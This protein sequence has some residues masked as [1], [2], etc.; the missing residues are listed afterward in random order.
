M[1]VLHF[2][3]KRTGWAFF[4][5]LMILGWEKAEANNSTWKAMANGNWSDG[6]NWYSGSAPGS[7]SSTTNT[8]TAAFNAVYV[9]NN[10]AS[11]LTVSIDQTGQNISN[12]TFGSVGNFGPFTFTGN[13]LHLSSGGSIVS[14]AAQIFESFNNPLILEPASATSDGSYT[15]AATG[16]DLFNFHGPISGGTTTGA[17]TLN[18]GRVVSPFAST[19]SIVSGSIS[20]G[21]AA[22]GLSLK[23]SV[24]GTWLL[25]GS[26]TYTGSTIVGTGTGIKLSGYLNPVTK[27]VLDGSTFNYSPPS[28]IV[29]QTVNGLTITGYSVLRTDNT[30]GS[31]GLHVGSITRNPKAILDI[32]TNNINTHFYV[33][34]TE[35]ASN[36]ILGPW[37]TMHAGASFLVT[38]AG[39]SGDALVSYTNA[40]SGT[41]GTLA[42]MT[43][44]TNN[45][46]YSQS[47][48]ITLVS[49]ITGNTLS[50][51]PSIITAGHTITLN[52]ILSVTNISGTGKLMAGSTHE[53][54]VFAPLVS[55]IAATI[56]GNT[57]L[58]YAAV[59]VG[60]G[61]N[62]TLSGNNDYTGGTT[63]SAGTL[64]LSG[65]GTL[66]ASG[67]TL[68]FGDNPN[69]NGR[70]E[71]GGTNQ[72]LSTIAGVGTISNNL[73]GS[74]S[75]LTL[76]YGDVSGT[77]A[78][79]IPTST[80]TVALAKTGSGTLT[81]TSSN[82]YTGGTTVNGG[83]LQISSKA[84]LG[85]TSGTLAVNGSGTVDLNGQAVGVGALIGNGTVLN[86]LPTSTSTLT[87]GN[88][89]MAG[90]FSGTI[91][92]NSG[93]GGKIALT[94]TGTNT[95]TLSGSNSYTGA[96]TIN[97]GTLSLGSDGALGDTSL[98]S[99][100]GGILQYTAAN[101]RDYS[102]RLI[103]SSA[104]IDTNGIDITFASNAVPYFLT[105]MGP[106]TLAL[107][108]SNG[109]SSLNLQGGVLSLASQHAVSPN[110]SI[111]FNGGTLRYSPD[112][113][114]ISYNYTG[115][116]Y[117]F[118]T[119]GQTIAFTQSL[120]GIGA[121]LTKMG[122]GTLALKG[123]NSIN[124]TTTIQNGTLVLG[125]DV[126]LSSGNYV[127]GEGT[128]SGILQIGDSAGS[129]QLSISNL[130]VSG[131]GTANAIVGGSSSTSILY[132]GPFTPTEYALRIGGD[133]TNQNNL[134]LSTSGSVT[135]S[136]SNTY[137]GRTTIS[138]GV[139]TLGN[140]NAIGTVGSIY[141]SGGTLQFTSANTTDYSS[142]FSPGSNV[143][144]DTNG[145]SVTLA[146]SINILSGSLSKTGSGTL[147]L[148]A[149][150]AYTGS[151]TLSAGTLQVDGFIA[152]S[153]TTINGGTLQ[154][155][156]QL[157]NV[158]LN[159][160]GSIAP[161]GFGTT[162]ILTAAQ[163]TWNPGGILHIDL[164]GGTTSDQLQLS[165][166]LIKGTSGSGTGYVFNF[167]ALPGFT[168]LGTYNIL[169]FGSTTFS[170]SDFSVTGAITG[171]FTV[172]GNTLQFTVTKTFST[173]TAVNFTPSQLNS[174]AI[175][176]PSATP[177]N[178]GIPNLLKYALDINPS[179]PISASDRAALPVVGLDSTT[180]PG[181]PYLTLRY[182]QNPSLT[183]TTLT[184]QT[185]DDL[186]TWQTVTPD[187][188][189]NI[190]TDPST[191]DPILVVGVKIQGTALK[192]I[193]LN[194]S[195]N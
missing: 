173:W 130:S 58:N 62:L 47:G 12:I 19:Y 108:G 171:F 176:G 182:R 104:S 148:T 26:N 15:F 63:I 34:T 189:Q 1:S 183:G 162:G 2:N 64:I 165:Q 18:L 185:S 107:T 153:T 129:A 60:Y 126:T 85:S 61:G 119:N 145:Q 25:S 21:S 17:I 191:G 181:T 187:L 186:L 128:N 93:T 33:H 117:S 125:K 82:A 92:D 139:L 88:G 49:D 50:N 71:L 29:S 131:T 66:G 79:L 3:F 68:T 152:A 184:V 124:G 188:L 16:Y 179:V 72:V 80:G 4:L 100:G 89:N 115:S 193:R 144:L 9:S 90:N 156:G 114:G 160:A 10:L 106:G 57:A 74:T 134:N 84:N 101:T 97:A 118:D 28:N 6:A 141:F 13:A 53:L 133:G 143:S 150:N 54:Y 32:D 91:T 177:Q 136:G 38:Y 76:G 102:N 27:L 45:Y 81:L 138:S 20:D 174:P 35:S 105:K 98:V 46:T 78:A 94:K 22:G 111:S 11:N 137:T 44:P 112:S 170:A 52:G 135:L 37:A 36:G 195:L 40:T 168:G 110:C 194:V 121:T 178:D 166:G 164:G 167:N 127:F 77:F 159:S 122:T 42:N 95:A 41:V 157:G 146:S 175:S 86:Y 51:A 155:Q 132:L 31:I 5:S 142:R 8:D 14:D 23:T 151:T 116:A 96:T 39:F 69:L 109:T 55:T 120:S 83:V 140:A 158:I 163:L 147:T 123:S 65:A 56:T 43:S 24:L 180:T 7:S 59:N 190:G 48:T 30:T 192:F 103:G 87:I 70:L 172:N 169:T 99:F 113:A 149:S 73:A 67:N 161:Q 75:T 154:G